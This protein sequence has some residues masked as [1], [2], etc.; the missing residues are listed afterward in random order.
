MGLS[1]RNP[2]QAP[3]VRPMSRL[4]SATSL[5]I[6]LLFLAQGFAVSA[7]PVKAVS[8]QGAVHCDGSMM[9]PGFAMSCC[10]QD[11]TDM[12]GCVFAHVA[13]ASVIVPNFSPTLAPRDPILVAAPLASAPQSLLRPPISSH[14]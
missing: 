2:A 7:A 3:T 12:A 1:L 13:V 10:D 4:R 9:N 6:G 11:C 8:A 14:A 5:L